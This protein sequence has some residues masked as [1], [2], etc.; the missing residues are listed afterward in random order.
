MDSRPQVAFSHRI[1]WQFFFLFHSIKSFFRH[2]H[3]FWTMDLRRGD[4]YV[5]KSEL[6]S[7]F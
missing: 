5:A 1:S 7:L 3:N 2:S 4:T 6:E